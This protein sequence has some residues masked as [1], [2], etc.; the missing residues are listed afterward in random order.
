MCVGLCAGVATD[1]EGITL[2]IMCCAYVCVFLGSLSVTIWWIVDMILFGINVYH[3][4][5]GAPLEPW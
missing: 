3:D 5:N 1:E 4:G 2:G